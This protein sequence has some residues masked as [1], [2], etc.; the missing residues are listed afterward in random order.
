MPFD[1]PHDPVLEILQRMRTLLT[2]R[3][4][5]IQ[6]SWARDAEGDEVCPES[7][8]AKRFCLIGAYYHI[9][10]IGADRAAGNRGMMPDESSVIRS[11]GFDPVDDVTGWNDKD[12]RT[13]RAVLARIDRA[14]EYRL[15]HLSSSSGDCR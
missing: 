8:E 7:P 13:K 1:Q 12:K 5:W 2:P 15:S 3:G 6:K 9:T 11:L 10:G 4:A 14:I